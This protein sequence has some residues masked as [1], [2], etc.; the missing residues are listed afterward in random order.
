[1]SIIYKNFPIRSLH[2]FESKIN[3]KQPLKFAL[4]FTFR[5][6]EIEE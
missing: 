2:T 1:M 6:H 3:A 5:Y 4:F